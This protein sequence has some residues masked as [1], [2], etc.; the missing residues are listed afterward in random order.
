VPYTGNPGHLHATGARADGPPRRAASDTAGTCVPRGAKPAGP[1]LRPGVHTGFSGPEVVNGGDQE[2]ST[3]IQGADTPVPGPGFHRGICALPRLCTEAPPHPWGGSESLSARPGR[4]P[5]GPVPRDL[6]SGPDQ[7]SS[8]AE[9]APL[10][11]AV[12]ELLWVAHLPLSVAV[13]T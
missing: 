7:L 6:V 11:V 3:T 2:G 9:A 4:M 8:R 12:T 1:N 5:D 13:E 10:A